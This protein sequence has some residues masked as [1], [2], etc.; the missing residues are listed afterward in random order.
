MI[1]ITLYENCI[2]NNDYDEVFS[3]SDNN[4][5]NTLER[6]LAGLNKFVLELDKVYQENSGTFVFDWTILPQGSGAQDIY[7]YNYMKVEIYQMTTPFPTVKYVRYCFI[8][9]IR[10]KNELVY[11][12]YSEDIWSSY[13]SKI[14]GITKSFL[15]NSR[16]L[17]Y[18]NNHNL[19]F[20]KLPVEYGGNN[21]ICDL[22]DRVST[23]G[24]VCII[25]EI[26]YYTPVQ[27]GQPTQTL[28]QLFLLTSSNN[29]LMLLPTAITMCEFFNQRTQIVDGLKLNE[30]GTWFSYSYQINKFYI[31]PKNIHDQ[32]VS[33]FNNSEDLDVA[34][35]LTYGGKSLLTTY[36]LT[37]IINTYKINNFSI[38]SFGTMTTQFPVKTNGTNITWKILVSMSR[39]GLHLYLDFNEE[40][41][42]ISSD[43]EY[44]LPYT[45]YASE[46][47]AQQKI[48]HDT[49]E[50]ANSYKQM[51]ADLD[52]GRGF[53]KTISGI[54]QAVGSGYSGNVGGVFRGIEQGIS[55][56]FDITES[57]FK[58]DYLEKERE[59]INREVFN[60]S[61]IS[62]T[63]GNAC[64]N[65]YYGLVWFKINPDNTKM[66][67]DSINYSGFKT[68][69]MFADYDDLGFNDS[70]EFLNRDE[71]I[72]YNAVKFA[73][74]NVYG[75][76]TSEIAN[77]L[78]NILLSGTIIWF[79]E[80]R[81]N[82]NYIEELIG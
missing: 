52:I 20:Y 1:K 44:E 21:S 13:S 23:D 37:E 49:K 60:T 15:E 29:T 72:N 42:E 81:T 11:L 58:K 14:N 71:P 65:A 78:E 24:R 12:D 45:Y 40:L 27:E 77:G 3:V 8:D 64:L 41:H 39:N 32:I 56:A 17:E 67:K 34:W 7:K 51:V 76:F 26:Q 48:N 25:A 38:K 16:I 63:R 57:A 50:I 36:P 28:S 18:K 66:V 46:I 10:L 82:D 30:G 54:G 9:K 35:D 80:N 33:A 53:N 61:V 74:I 5:N 47:V 4:A 70:A 79:N 6:Y 22:I 68:Y 2:L 59:I 43:F 31:L 69:E 62:R 19:E 75:R 55:G 73:K